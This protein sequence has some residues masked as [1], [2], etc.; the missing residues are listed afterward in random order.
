MGLSANQGAAFPGVVDLAFP[1]RCAV[2]SVL[3]VFLTLFLI[4]FTFICCIY[5]KFCN[6]VEFLKSR[7]GYLLLSS[8]VAHMSRLLR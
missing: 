5:V 1:V 8:W 6:Y 3:N 7:S 2:D 4:W